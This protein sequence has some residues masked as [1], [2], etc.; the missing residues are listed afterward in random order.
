MKI[1]AS[2]LT[3]SAWCADERGSWEDHGQAPNHIR[4]ILLRHRSIIEILNEEEL[5]TVLTSADYHGNAAAW[6]DRPSYRAAVARIASRI[7]IAQAHREA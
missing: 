1:R 7:R 6:D 5:E 3:I 4:S 2:A